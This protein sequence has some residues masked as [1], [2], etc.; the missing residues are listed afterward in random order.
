MITL[1]QNANSS[2]FLFEEEGQGPKAK[3]VSKVVYLSW[4][5]NDFPHLKKVFP[6][7]L[8]MIKVF[9]TEAQIVDQLMSNGEGNKMA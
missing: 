6:S 1:A 7:S 2:G 3:D 4:Y 8:T 5:L 9:G